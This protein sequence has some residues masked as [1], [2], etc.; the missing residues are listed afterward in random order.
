KI[1]P[2]L[3]NP[4]INWI[5]PRAIISANREKMT[6]KNELRK[7]LPLWNKINVPVMYMQGENDALI[8]TSNA[9][10]A[11]EHLVKVPFLDIMIFK[12]EPHVILH[13]RRQVIRSKI[14]EMLEMV[15]EGTEEKR[16]K[17]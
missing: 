6:H 17:K 2:S 7:M 13:S 11:R 15:R 8:K 10:F 4:V 12:D 16:E 1:A 3:E 9:G 14:F 5:L